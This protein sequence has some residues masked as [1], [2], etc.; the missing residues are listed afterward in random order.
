MISRTISFHF[1]KVLGRELYWVRISIAIGTNS[2]HAIYDK[3]LFGTPRVLNEYLPKEQSL[4]DCT[5][6]KLKIVQEK[7]PGL[8]HCFYQCIA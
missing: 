4:P 3:G 8:F 6:L 2:E 7:I 1:L 5:L